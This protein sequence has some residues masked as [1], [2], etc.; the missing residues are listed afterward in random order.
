MKEAVLAAYP[1]YCDLSLAALGHHPLW[2]W[3]GIGPPGGT[4]QGA[5]FPGVTWDCLLSQ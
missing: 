3:G 2:S 4:Q 5:P 1:S